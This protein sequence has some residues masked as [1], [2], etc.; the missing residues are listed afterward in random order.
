[1]RAN[2]R[3]NVHQQWVGRYRGLQGAQEFAGIPF[4]IRVHD[5]QPFQGTETEQ[6]LPQSLDPFPARAG[7][8]LANDLSHAHLN[9]RFDLQEIPQLGTRPGNTTTAPDV[10]QCIQHGKHPGA[11][12]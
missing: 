1:M 7:V 2:N 8:S 5:C 12:A 9:E 11:Q 6:K 3:G 4:C 10:L